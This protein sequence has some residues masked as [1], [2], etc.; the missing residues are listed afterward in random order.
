MA[1]Q[2]QFSVNSVTDY[3]LSTSLVHCNCHPSSTTNA[4][5]S[6]SAGDHR[7]AAPTNLST[8]YQARLTRARLRML[9]LPVYPSVLLHK[10]TAFAGRRLTILFNIL[11][12]LATLSLVYSCIC[13]THNVDT[14][15]SI[16]KA[17]ALGASLQLRQLGAAQMTFD[18]SATTCEYIHF[19]SPP[20]TPHVSWTK[21]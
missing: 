13:C 10:T 21:L 15:P 12:L 2:N 19:T 9:L 14:M 6:R 5:K 8:V 3:T 20:I 1:E 11:V 17:F 16:F 18:S 4:S 7:S